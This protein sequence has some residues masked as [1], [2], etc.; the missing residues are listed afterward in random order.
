MRR[1]IAVIACL[2]SIGCGTKAIHGVRPAPVTKFR[3]LQAQLTDEV[4]R[5]LRPGPSEVFF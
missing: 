1:S 5:V 4:G 2:L 3:I